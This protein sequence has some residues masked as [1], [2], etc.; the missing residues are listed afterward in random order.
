MV[1]IY[2]SLYFGFEF[3]IV[4]DNE[5][6]YADIDMI[7][8]KDINFCDKCIKKTEALQ[9]RDIKKDNDLYWAYLGNSKGE[10][11]DFRNWN[12]GVIDLIDDMD[13]QIEYIGNYIVNN[14]LDKW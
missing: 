8:E 5:E 6:E 13:I 1:V 14:V 3:D 9:L 4:N 11:L 2:E 12:S 7:R 10:K